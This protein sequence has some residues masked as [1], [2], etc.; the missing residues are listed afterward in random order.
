MHLFFSFTCRN[1]PALRRPGLKS[2][3]QIRQNRAL[4]LPGVLYKDTYVA[5]SEADW[6]RQV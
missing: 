5:K 4:N 2:L 3:C 1:V 6:H